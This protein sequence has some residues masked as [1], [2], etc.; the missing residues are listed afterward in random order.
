MWLAEA[1]DPIAAIAAARAVV[2]R[3]FVVYSSEDS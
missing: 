1:A 3:C 2:L